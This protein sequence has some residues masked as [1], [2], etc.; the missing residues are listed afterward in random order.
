MAN[1]RLK[2]GYEKVPKVPGFYEC[3]KC[4][5]IT[6]RLSQ[7]ERHLSTD[8][9]IRLTNANKEPSEVPEFICSNS[10]KNY[11]HKSSLF[12]HTKKC[13]ILN[14]ENVVINKNTPNNE[15]I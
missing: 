9:H 7:Y 10:K 5:Y 12:K 13:I 1:I 14:N 3:Q 6:V 4:D 11:K 15:I 8:K 2:N